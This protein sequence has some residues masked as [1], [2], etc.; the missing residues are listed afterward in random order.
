MHFRL[1]SDELIFLAFGA[2]KLTK[3]SSVLF[4][5]LAYTLIGSAS[6]KHP[7]SQKD[8]LIQACERLVNYYPIP[9]DSLDGVA[10]GKM[11]TSDAEFILRTD[12]T[13]VTKGRDQIVETLLARASNTTS[14]HVTG[15][16]YV[17]AASETVGTGISYAIVFSA[18]KETADKPKELDEQSLSAVVSYF[19]KFKFENGQCFFTQRKVIVDFLNTKR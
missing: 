14:R 3:L 9:R 16:V 1:F 7:P 12:V 15:S 17:N 11:F 6:A 4:I 19:D 18:S 2:F 8:Q 5:L 10:Y 13:T